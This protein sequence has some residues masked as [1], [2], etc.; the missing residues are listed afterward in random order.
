MHVQAA[1]IVN[2]PYGDRCIDYGE[3]SGAAINNIDFS[4]IG[5]C[6]ISSFSGGIGFRG[7]YHVWNSVG[8]MSGSDFNLKRSVM[9]RPI[10]DSLLVNRRCINSYRSEIPL[11]LSYFN[12]KWTGY[13]G[14]K[15][16][17]LE[18][19][20]NI[21][22]TVRNGRFIAYSSGF[23]T[24]H[25]RFQPSAGA[26]YRIGSWSDKS[27]HAL[28]EIDHRDEIV[29]SVTRGSWDIHLGCSFRW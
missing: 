13:I 10:P 27:L 17:W 15:A 29:Q 18:G 23:S 24:I 25:V 9:K 20:T 21:R 26:T 6:A 19:T 5:L 22:T 4:V 12:E 2:I 28:L 8:F 3:V 1:S 14:F 16:V 7:V 11:Y